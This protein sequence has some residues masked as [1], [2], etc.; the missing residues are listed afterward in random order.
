MR[1]S[2]ELPFD[3]VA[4]VRPKVTRWNTYYPGAYGTWLPEARQ[5]LSDNWHKEPLDCQLSVTLRFVVP[6]PKSHL[7]TGRNAGTVKPSAPAYPHP[8]IDNYVKAALD[9]MS[10]T[11]YTD[12]KLVIELH[13]RKVY[14]TP[15]R[16][17]VE[18]RQADPKADPPALTS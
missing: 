9:A 13:A 3:P 8:D 4:A 12:D 2:V 7:G 16:I 15:G 11:V 10:G 17:E 1:E 6:R 5:W 18:L 14:G